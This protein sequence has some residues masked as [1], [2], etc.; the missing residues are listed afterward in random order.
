MFNNANPFCFVMVK[1]T[2]IY[3]DGKGKTTKCLGHIYL[4]AAQNKE[5]V[6][7]QF[8]KTG[9]NCGECIFFK[10]LGISRWF[11]LGKEEFFTSKSNRRDFERMIVTGIQDLEESLRKS[12][13]DILLLDELG[14][15]LHFKLAKWKQIQDLLRYVKEEVI[16]TGR[17]IPPNIRE[18]SDILIR[19][20][21][22]KHPYNRGIEAREGID[23]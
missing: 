17:R 10:E 20:D 22:K 1:L 5:I 3:G 7:V 18:K 9:E 2:M 15:V 14:L 6:V 23:F 12:N 21:E 11:F 16:I 4:D 13:P 19:I 8:L